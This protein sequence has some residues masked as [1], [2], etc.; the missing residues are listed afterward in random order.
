[1]NYTWLSECLCI[2]VFRHSTTKKLLVIIITYLCYS[3]NG[4]FYT[5]GLSQNPQHHQCILQIHNK[6]SINQSIN[7]PTNQSINQSILINIAVYLV[8]PIFWPKAITK[9]WWFPE[10]VTNSVS[11]FLGFTMFF[12]FV[13]SFQLRC[14]PKPIY[15]RN[16]LPESPAQLGAQLEMFRGHFP[17]LRNARNA[18]GWDLFLRAATRRGATQIWKH[19]KCQQHMMFVR[20]KKNCILQHDFWYVV[21]LF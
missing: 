20:S 2:P 19:A 18:D 9:N 6:K 12:Y 5:S 21:I 3:L 17:R 8:S 11:I 7:Q 1:M 14:S 10:L 15:G 16:K 13:S 4:W